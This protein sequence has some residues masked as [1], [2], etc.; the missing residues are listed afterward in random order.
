MLKH[1]KFISQVEERKNDSEKSSPIQTKKLFI[2]SLPLIHKVLNRK[3]KNQKPKKKLQIK[4]P[5]K[6][7]SSS[8]FINQMRIKKY[9]NSNFNK[10]KTII[11]KYNKAII[12]ENNENNKKP[13]FKL[14]K[15]HTVNNTII[16]DPNGNNNLNNEERNLIQG[17]LSKMQNKKIIIK[18]NM[19]QKINSINNKN[20]FI[21]N[22]LVNKNKNT[23]ISKKENSDYCFYNEYL[24]KNVNENINRNFLNINDN[25]FSK[26]NNSIFEE[27]SFSFDVDDELK[28][29]NNNGSFLESFFEE[30]DCYK[31]FLKK[32][33]P[34]YN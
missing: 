6:K 28:N 30:K 19:Q 34:L 21:Q 7:Q 31:E 15:Y 10:I 16:I 33:Q 20:V 1:Q 27:E 24:F 5:I 4:N 23:R 12:N 3:T 11:D 13:D 25:F 17:Y 2:N 18:V 22:N 9:N 8:N 14:K 32:P 26:R 29:K